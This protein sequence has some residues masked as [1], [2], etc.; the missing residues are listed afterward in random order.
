MMYVVHSSVKVYTKET[1][2]IE[3][4]LVDSSIPLLMHELQWQEELLWGTIV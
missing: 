3:I 4:S 1:S 2:Q